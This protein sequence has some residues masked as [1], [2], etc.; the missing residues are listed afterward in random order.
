MA[1]QANDDP[2]ADAAGSGF[3]APLSARLPARI[4]IQRQQTNL[5]KKDK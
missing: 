1:N 2:T 3:R 4:I 5:Q